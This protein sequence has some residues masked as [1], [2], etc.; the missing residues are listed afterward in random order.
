MKGTFHNRALDLFD[1]YSRL[2]DSENAGGLTR[3]RT[4][5]P[6]KFGEVVG[7]VQR[8]NRIPPAA[9]IHHI[10]PI[11]NEIVQRASGMTK[12]DAAIHTTSTLYLQP[13]FGQGLINGEEVLDALLDRPPFRRLPGEFDK[14]GD[15]THLRPA[16]LPAPC[17]GSGLSC[18]QKERF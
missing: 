17:F 5:Q 18:I 10:I 14:T 4:N 9:P 8:A 3:R 2:A 11:R 16:L 7:G 13:V 6:G 12:R 1:G 15:L